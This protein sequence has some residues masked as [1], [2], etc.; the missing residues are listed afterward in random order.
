MTRF[1]RITLFLALLGDAKCGVEISPGYLILEYLPF[2]EVG[3]DGA[4]EESCR[5]L[6]LLHPRQKPKNHKK[7]DN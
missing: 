3:V 7:I 5:R 1:K 2:L 4:Q 6:S